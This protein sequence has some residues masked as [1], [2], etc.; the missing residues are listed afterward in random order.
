M[1]P[2]EALE[3]RIAE[4]LI[5]R[6]EPRLKPIMKD[7]LSSSQGRDILAEAVTDMVGDLADGSG[8]PDGLSFM[9]QIVLSLA[10]R[11]VGRP[12]FRRELAA[13]VTDPEASRAP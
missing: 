11:M 3:E 9:E 5:R 7:F 4:R 6:L 8:D 12:R 13:L 1:W 10:T 2:H